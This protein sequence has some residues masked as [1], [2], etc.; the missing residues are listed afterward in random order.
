M[1]DQAVANVPAI[2]PSYLEA[3]GRYALSLPHGPPSRFH[4]IDGGRR[5]D[6]CQSHRE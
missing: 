1:T 4:P 6:L 2:D 3:A 5:R